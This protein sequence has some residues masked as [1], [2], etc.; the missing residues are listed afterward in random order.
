MSFIVIIDDYYYAPVPLNGDNAMMA[1]V[2]L[3]VRP[4]V[5]LSVCPTPDP[6]SSMEER[7]KLKIGRKEAQDTGNP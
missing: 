5:C 1:V 3:S 2:S 7:S 6:K 4:S